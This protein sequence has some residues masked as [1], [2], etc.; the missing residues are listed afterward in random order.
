MHATNLRADVRRSCI[1]WRAGQRKGLSVR[2]FNWLLTSDHEW[3][4]RDVMFTCQKPAGNPLEL[5]VGQPCFHLWFK[6]H[7][8]DAT[9][10]SVRSRILAVFWISRQRKYEY[11]LSVWRN[12]DRS[13][14]P[15]CAAWEQHRRDQCWWNRHIQVKR[16]SRQR[17][18]HHNNHHKQ[19]P[20]YQEENS[21]N[22]PN[23][24]QR[25]MEKIQWALLP[26]NGWATWWTRQMHTH[27]QQGTSTIIDARH[28][29]W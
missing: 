25:G 3:S 22:H 13:I 19:Q 23:K 2:Y 10:S 14:V 20:N 24:Q 15:P 27:T 21:R 29:S 4:T 16:Q 1:A 18:Q 7:S 9:I 11:A 28:Q 5:N 8:T 26:K 12:L 6:V 17:P